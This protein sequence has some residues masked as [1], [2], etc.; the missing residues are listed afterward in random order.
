V[1]PADNP[2]GFVPNPGKTDAQ[3]W[4][5]RLGRTILAAQKENFGF[6]KS[7]RLANNVAYVRIDAFYE[8]ATA[9]AT[10]AAEMSQV[11]DA[12]ALIIDLR[13]NGGGSGDTGALV[14]AY[15]FDDVPVHLTD[16]YT[17]GARRTEPIW[18]SPVASDLRFGAAKPVYVLV[19]K[20]TFS[21]AEDFVYALQALKRVT[22]IGEPTKGGAHN[23]RGF[24]LDDHFLASIPNR[25]AI[26]PVTHTDWEGNGIKP[27]VA[28]LAA[29]ALS[30]ALALAAKAIAS[31]PKR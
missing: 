22:V 10:V 28:V 15:L 9:S 18:T 4:A 20:A 1:L 6:G 21:A 13:D 29:D 11:A 7:E 5:N 19:D 26:N 3:G 2:P 17:R 24:K 14:S 25:V 16:R 23:G 30:T 8:P 27:D 31:G 12:S